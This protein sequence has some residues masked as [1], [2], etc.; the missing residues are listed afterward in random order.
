M[1]LDGET[2][3]WVEPVGA[4]GNGKVVRAMTPTATG[5]VLDVLRTAVVLTDSSLSVSY[6]NNAA[7]VL[8]GI[9]ERR[10][11]GANLAEVLVPDDPICQL[12]GVALAEQQ[13]L[14]RF[15]IAMRTQSG[16]SVRVDCWATPLSTA[17]RP[18]RM[19]VELLETDSQWGRF[20]AQQDLEIEQAN[21]LMV[22]GFA[23]EVKNPL[24]GIRGAAQLLD[25]KIKDEEQRE[26]TGVIISEVDRLRAL[27][28]RMSSSDRSPR[29]HQSVNIH[30]VLERV[31]TLLS[32]YEAEGIAIVGDY[33]PSIPELSADHDR[34]IQVFLNITK[35]AL[36]AI[37][38]AGA[39]GTVVI[40]TRVKPQASIGDRPH[41]LVLAVDIEDN[42]PGIPPDLQGRVFFPL[43][44]GRARGTGLGLSIAR[45][46]LAEHDGSLSFVSKPGKTVFRALLPIQMTGKS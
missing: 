40:R 31:R 37:Q 12:V 27:I 5:E 16:V 46:Y 11:I 23:H 19:V 8:L 36:E 18:D 41:R 24:S 26:Y 17:D 43:V 21:R 25:R 15:G 34:L 3:V 39:R 10:V 28:D 45:S 44:T 14:A 4:S 13:P 29:L 20:R 6:L 33:D 42:G 32:V 38:E 9:S 7:E 35:N 22:R 1:R 30:E 2:H